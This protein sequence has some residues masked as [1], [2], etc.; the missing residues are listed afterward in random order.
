MNRLNREINQ[1]LMAKMEV[2]AR[3]ELHIQIL[4]YLLDVVCPFEVYVLILLNIISTFAGVY[5]YWLLIY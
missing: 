5:V 3:Y 4:N 1:H 2:F